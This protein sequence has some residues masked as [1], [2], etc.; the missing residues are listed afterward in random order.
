LQPLPA[1]AGARIPPPAPQY[2]TTTKNASPI[3]LPSYEGSNPTARLN[4]T[5]TT[6]ASHGIRIAGVFAGTTT[7][8]TAGLSG[9]RR[10]RELNRHY[11]VGGPVQ[12]ELVKRNRTPSGISKVFDRIPTV[13]NRS[14]RNP[15]IDPF[16]GSILPHQANLHDTYAVGH[17]YHEKADRRTAVCSKLHWSAR[18]PKIANC[19][20]I[21]ST[22][23]GCNYKPRG[24][25]GTIIS[26]HA[27][28]VCTS[29][30]PNKTSG[31][32][33]KVTERLRRKSEA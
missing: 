9:L 6:T 4:S 19:D 16:S 7:P 24:S 33:D 31:I 26:Y 5:A 27:Y 32:R 25:Y 2:P 20:R 15:R 29:E 22:R 23:P 13:R 28:K 18:L 17:L 8:P 30:R 12:Y 3:P 1:C 11:L 14:T 10:L 21:R